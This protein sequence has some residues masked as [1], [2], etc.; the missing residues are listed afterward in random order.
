M[1]K[2]TAVLLTLLLMTGLFT[3]CTN[4]TTEQNENAITVVCTTF[5]SW[6][7]ARNVAAG[8]DINVVLLNQSGSDLHS[9][10]PSAKDI[11]EIAKADVFIYVGGP[12]DEWVDKALAQSDNPNRKV[13]NMMTVLGENIK[14]EE[15]IEGAT[16]ND[17]DHGEEE[18]HDHD[19]DGVDDH[20][21]TEATEY[22]EHVWLSIKNAEKITA[23]ITDALIA[24][25][26]A[27]TATLSANSKA[28]TQKLAA[29]DARYQAAVD[30]SGHKTL[31]V[32]DRFPFR[33][34]TDDYH[35][36]Y[37][38]AFPGCTAETEA[39]FATVAFLSD[40]INSLG[41]HSVI[42]TESADMRVP[43]TII[44]NSGAQ[45]VAVLTLNSMQSM[46][47]K[48]IDA[49]ATYLSVMEKNLET[50]KTALQ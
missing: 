40:K 17:H 32:A 19:G 15:A 47:K 7:W 11:M 22:D 34:L 13:I 24:E 4:S 28:Y 14:A 26:P 25:D 5:P 20:A 27:D 8:T 10:Q 12:S 42:V 18:D 21:E 3:G 2:L 44:D 48:T 36:N 37:F 6:D 49:G 39:S 23:A 9:W 45:N 43:N 29:L 35:L 31:L 38:A 30:A 16:G 33:Y 46:P 50:L 41:L 1:K